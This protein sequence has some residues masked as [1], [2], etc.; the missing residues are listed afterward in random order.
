MIKLI[1]PSGPGGQPPLDSL[2]AAFEEALRLHR[3][4]DLAKALTIYRRV[5]TAYP[6][7]ADALQMAGVC[8]AQLGNP[9]AGVPLIRQAIALR[10]NAPGYQLNL[11]NLLR[12]LNKLEDAAAA[13]RQAV[14]LDPFYAEALNNLGSALRLLGRPEEAL[15]SLQQ[16]VRLKPGSIDALRNLGAVLMDLGRTGE[17]ASVLRALLERVPDDSQARQLLEQ[18]EQG[19]GASL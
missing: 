7:H 16:A 2:A 1:N 14:S 8:T 17:A 10:P 3:A 19:G 6:R 11:G 4:G 5:L 9:S 18:A 12:M 13:Y 15:K